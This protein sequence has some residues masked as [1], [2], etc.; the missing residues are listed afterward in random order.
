MSSSKNKPVASAILAV[1]NSEKTIEK[2]LKSLLAQ[3]EPIEVIIVDDGSTDN[4]KSL[5]MAVI[6]LFKD[7]KVMIYSQPHLGPA[8]ARNF[9]AQTASTDILLFVDADM[10][11]D[12]HYVRRLIRPIREGKV[13]GTYTT[14]ERVLNWDNRLALYWNY[15]EGWEDRKRFPPAKQ[16][17]PTKATDSRNGRIGSLR[18]IAVASEGTDYRAILKKE[19][20]KVGGFDNIGYTDSWTLFQKLGVR[21]LATSA[22]CYH[23]NPDNYSAVFRQAKWVAKRPY[24]LGKLGLFVALIR[25]SIISSIFV[26]ISK[27]ILHKDFGFLPFKIFYDL[28]RSIGIGEMIVSGKLSK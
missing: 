19:F 8:I 25:S 28:G 3:S 2:A 27:S 17:M 15:Q 24:K 6:E 10:V 12:R 11:F 22:I 1:Y 18:E 7:A 5:M 13:I 26:G 9:G 14:E 4:T 16:G 20:K 21:P 23:K